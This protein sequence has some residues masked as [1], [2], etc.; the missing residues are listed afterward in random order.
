MKNRIKNYGLFL[1]LVAVLTIGILPV[2]TA[3]AQALE[4][5]SMLQSITEFTVKAGHNTQFREGV[6][7]WKNCYLEN[8]G[9]WT[10]SMWSRVQGEGNVYIL[11][12]YMGSWAEMDDTSDEAGQA[13]QHLA[14]NLINTSVESATSN[15]FRTVPSLSNSQ[16]MPNNVISVQAWRVNN[17]TLFMKMAEEVISAI[18]NV[19]GEP[20]WYWRSAIGGDLK[21]PHYFSVTP[22]ENFAAMDV[23]RDGVWTIVENELG[24]SERERLQADYRASVDQSWSYIYRRVD[25]LSHQP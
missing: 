10:W 14:Q 1:T 12:S 9:D 20:R 24:N 19:E 7:A 21:A 11:S 5:G 4:E 17:G 2:N 25:E 8:E 18:S 13:C 6:K 22:Y 23:S 15:L 3:N 16:D